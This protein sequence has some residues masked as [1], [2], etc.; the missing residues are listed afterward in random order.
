MNKRTILDRVIVDTPALLN[1]I[2]HCREQQGSAQGLLMGVVQPNVG[3][4]TD[5]LLVTQTMPGASKIQMQDLLRQMESDSQKLMD[6]NEI[7]FYMSA[8]MGLC[9]HIETLTELLSV[10]KK[11][12]NSVMLI[13][14][15]QKSDYGMAP[16]KAYRLSEKA[17]NTI[18]WTPGSSLDAHFVQESINEN[19]LEVKEMFEEVPIKI[20]RSHMQQAYLFD[21]IQPQMP[22]FNTN[23][24]KLVTPDY[25]CNHVYQAVTATEDLTVNETQRQEQLMK[26]YAKL[27]PQQKDGKSGMKGMQQAANDDADQNKVNYFLLSQQVNALCTQLEECGISA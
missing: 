11:F 22:A 23:V 3:Q 26:A 21:H 4:Q 10:S 6:T 7:G 24:F 25:Y 17:I 18:K 20:Q 14:D 9:F 1:M 12:K 19:K 8:R 15:Q 13:Y 27:K 2:K 16:L 5:S